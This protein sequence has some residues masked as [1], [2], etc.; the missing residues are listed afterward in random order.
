MALTATPELWFLPFALVIGCWVAWSDLTTMKIPNKAV[1]AL[2]TV[3]FFIGLLALPL[4]VWAWRW[5][6]FGVAIVLTF[7]LSALGVMGAG[8]AKF[9]AASMPFVALPL[10]TEYA[11]VLGIMIALT[12]PLQRLW[13]RSSFARSRFAQWESME[14]REFP[15][16][17]ALGPA[18]AIYLAIVAV[19]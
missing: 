19:A 3:F 17:V 11:I 7:L 9:L 4:D 1:I 18:L 8:D 12:F 14:R 6:H 16:G 2:L 13:R 10:F 5:V 15:M